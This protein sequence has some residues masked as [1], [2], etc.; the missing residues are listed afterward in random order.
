M[1]LKPC[2]VR[3]L[4]KIL[5]SYIRKC[6]KAMSSV[7]FLRKMSNQRKI[8]QN[9]LVCNN[10]GVIPRNTQG[11]VNTEKLISVI[12][13]INRFKKFKWSPQ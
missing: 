9:Y 1:Q 2:L 6:L 4:Y 13:C 5:N 10:S 3:K 12:H 11:H 7:S 8:T